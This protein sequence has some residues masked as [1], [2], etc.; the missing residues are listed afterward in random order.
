MAMAFERRWAAHARSEDALGASEVN[1]LYTVAQFDWAICTARLRV[2]ARSRRNAAQWGASAHPV[3]V[4]TRLARGVRAFGLERTRNQGS[5]REAELHTRKRRAHRVDGG[6]HALE[7]GPRVGREGDGN[8]KSRRFR[9][10][11]SSIMR[12][13]TPM[14]AISFSLCCRSTARDATAGRGL[15]RDS[16]DARRSSL[17]RARVSGAKRARA[18][19]RE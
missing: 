10:T 6:H 11:R 7:R 4:R 13:A 12:L 8:P 5:T 1:G 15:L 16:R 18:G 2:L 9:P 14:P 17:P 19:S 3:P